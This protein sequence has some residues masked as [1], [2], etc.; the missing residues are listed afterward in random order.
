MPARPRADF[1]GKLFVVTGA[2]SGLGREIARRLACHEGAHIVVS[3]RRRERLEELKAY[4]EG[5]CASRV[6]IV[7]ADLAD[8]A[9]A[10]SL[11][12]WA[13]AH[14]DVFGLVNCAGL[15][16][17][18]RT[19]DAPAGASERI[20]AVNLVAGM[21]L[22]MLFLPAFLERGSGAILTVTSVAGVLTTPYQTVYSASKHAMQAFMEGLA[23]EYRGRGVSFTTM[24]PGGIDTELLTLSGLDRKIPAGS[25]VN[26][27]PARA[28]RIAVR[29]LKSGRGRC[30]P[31]LMNKALVLVSR[32]VPRS[33]IERSAERLYDPGQRAP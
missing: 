14:G 28:A 21:R 7:T 2:S 20:L 11:Y 12:R 29:A 31:G 30:V 13:T 19:L 27:S 33:L 3:A 16:Y 9:E 32:F 25:A 23:W 5:R 17:Y 22:V 26:M 10:E 8:P 6:S 1:R 24:L 18:G 4:V 15:T